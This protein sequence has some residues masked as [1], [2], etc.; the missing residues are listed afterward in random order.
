MSRPAASLLIFVL[1]SFVVPGTYARDRQAA[2][3]EIYLYQGADRAQRLLSGARKEGGLS[4][5]TTMTPEDAGPLVAAFEE[6]Y[7]IKVRM[8]RG[9]NQKLVQRA[10]AEARAGKS[11]VDVFEG[12]G[13]GMEILH[14]EALLE[15]FWSPAFGDIP[16]EA[17]PRHAHYA[18]D[19]LLFFVMGYNT[20]LV[21]PEDVPRS[22]EDLLQPRWSGNFGIEASDIIWFAAVAKAM[23]EEKGLA[24]FRKLAAMEPQIR[25]GHTLMTE[26]VAAGDIP[27]ALTLYNQ[28]VDKLKERGAP[29]DWKPLPPAF[30]RADGIGVAKQAPHPHAALLFADFVLS[31]EGQRFI[32]AA[33][34]V[35]V[36]RKVESSFD[37]R[38]FRIIEL[39]PVVDAWDTWERRWQALFLKGQK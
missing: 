13:H 20:R 7:G 30:G 37:Q 3:R 35:P 15:K 16:P 24:Y 9:I 6:R 4:L 8:W 38:N 29:I 21:K 31:P 26:L 28:A 5:Y 33:S 18:P 39:A 11:A 32:M 14:R 10:L 23:G 1:A 34:R 19:N 36:N 2:N 22:Y 12:S 25:S 17:F 27:M